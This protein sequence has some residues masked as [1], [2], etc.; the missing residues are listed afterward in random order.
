MELLLTQTECLEILNKSFGKNNYNLIDYRIE[1]A[2]ANTIGFL[3]DYYKLITDIN[4]VS[5]FYADGGAYIIQLYTTKFVIFINIES[6]P[7]FWYS[8]VV[9]INK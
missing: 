9:I 8:F 1:N 7:D 5:I 6:V 4:D 3:G 2:S